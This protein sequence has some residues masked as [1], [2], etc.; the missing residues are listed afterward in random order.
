M[1]RKRD[2]AGPSPRGTKVAAS[3]K[4]FDFS[5]PMVR[6]IPRKSLAN[7]ARVAASSEKPTKELRM[8]M[9]GRV[10]RGASKKK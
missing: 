4:D 5:G 3:T 10:V 9:A 6:S 8:L 1:T 7:L 2:E